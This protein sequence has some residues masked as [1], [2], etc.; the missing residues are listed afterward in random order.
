MVGG[1]GDG[2]RGGGEKG[3]KLRDQFWCVYASQKLV[4]VNSEGLGSKVRPAPI[5]FGLKMY[6]V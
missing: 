5:N 2:A 4:E 6:C 3:S 1:A